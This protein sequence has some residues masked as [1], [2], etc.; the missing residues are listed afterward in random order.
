MSNKQNDILLEG[1]ED[2]SFYGVMDRELAGKSAEYLA[3][4]QRYWAQPRSVTMGDE[5]GHEEYNSH[6]EAFLAERA[7]QH[8]EQYRVEDEKG[9]PWAESVR[10][11]DWGMNEKGNLTLFHPREDDVVERLVDRAEDNFN[12]RNDL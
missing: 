2:G 1:T 6:R 9:M 8:Y 10:G 3:E 12:H 7:D 4:H 5:D 11:L